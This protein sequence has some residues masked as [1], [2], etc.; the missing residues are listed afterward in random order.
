V[1]ATPELIDAALRIGEP[2]RARL[3]LER[4]E[5]WAPAS[6]TALV[7][8]MVARCRGVLAFDAEEA[9]LCFQAALRHHDYRIQ[10]YER[11]RTQLA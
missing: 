8:G 2:D 11:A 5:A 9:E 10:P 6:G 4:L 7:A 1:L 3:A